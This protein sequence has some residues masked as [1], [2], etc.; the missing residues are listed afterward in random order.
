MNGQAALRSVGGFSSVTAAIYASNTIWVKNPTYFLN[1]KHP[2]FVAPEY[3][4]VPRP[5]CVVVDSKRG[6]DPTTGQP[7]RNVGGSTPIRVG[8][9]GGKGT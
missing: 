2:Q 6:I 4:E 8:N 9:R 1:S 3:I 7:F 5:M